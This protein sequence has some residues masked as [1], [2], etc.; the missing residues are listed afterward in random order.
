MI[1]A[2]WVMD[3]G[4]DAYV[5]DVLSCTPARSS[6]TPMTQLQRGA[7]THPALLFHGSYC[8]AGPL[9]AYMPAWRCSSTLSHATQV[10]AVEL[11]CLWYR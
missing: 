4:K 5:V 8:T 1:A 7:A 11:S 9:R 10:A 3:I 6:H 2:M